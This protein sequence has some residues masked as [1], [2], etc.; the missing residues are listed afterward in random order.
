[1]GSEGATTTSWEVA[2]LHMSHINKKSGEKVRRHV[3]QPCSITIVKQ[4]RLNM[5]AFSNSSSNDDGL[6]EVADPKCDGESLVESVP[7]VAS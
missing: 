6:N 3:Q 4:G 5:R 1:M 2:G 7:S